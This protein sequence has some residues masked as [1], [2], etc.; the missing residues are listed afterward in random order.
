[1]RDDEGMVAGT[2]LA[3]TVARDA[4]ELPAGPFAHRIRTCAAEDCHLIYV[5]A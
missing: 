1:M 4:V 5:D 2:H 3:A